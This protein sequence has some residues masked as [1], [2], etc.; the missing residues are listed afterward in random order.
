MKLSLAFSPCP[1]DTFAFHAMINNL[2]D[3][4]GLEFNV[5][6]ADVEELNILANKGEFDITKL[7]YNCYF[8]VLTTYIMLRCGSALGF[9]N[10]P[11]FIKKAGKTLPNNPKVAIPGYNTSAFLL[12]RTA[13]PQYCDFKEMVFSKIEAA[14]LNGDVDAG[15]II[16]EGRFTYKHKGLDLICDLGEFW[17]N[18]F[19]LPIP[20]GGIA[21]RR[22][23][24]IDLANKINRVLRRS[25]EYAFKNPNSSEDFI[26][27]HAQEIT[28]DVQ[29]KHIKLFVNDFTLDIGNLGE[30]S[31]NFMY[32]AFCKMT[33][34][35]FDKTINLCI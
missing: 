5:H 10:G 12:F 21:I 29:S 22:D 6:L 14:I 11:L 30:R 35:N 16:H 32:E 2:V 33:N 8:S 3:T 13:Y 28:K 26:T 31:V 25:I 19:N 18:S 4:E 17:E 27:L 7:S 23:Y 24:D 20:L 15:V 1:N 34:K 9:G